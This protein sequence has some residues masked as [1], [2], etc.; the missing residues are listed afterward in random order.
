[1]SVLLIGDV[2]QFLSGHRQLGAEKEMRITVDRLFEQ[3]ELSLAEVVSRSGLGQERIEAIIAGRWLPSP[4]ERKA[5]ADVLQ[6]SVDGVDW[7][8]TMSPRNIR[9]HRYGLPEDL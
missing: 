5:I 7:G 2:G 3:S 9:Y 4:S 1:M 8:H 6:V